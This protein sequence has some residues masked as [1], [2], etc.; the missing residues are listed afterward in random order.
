MIR[1]LSRTLVLVYAKIFYHHKVYGKKNII[2][3]K[4]IVASNHL[5]YL[6]PPLIGIS[7]PGT[8]HFL[9]K[10]ELFKSR[11]LAWFLKKLKAHPIQRG[12]ENVSV[13]R[14]A[15]SLLKKEEKIVLFPE[16]HRSKTGELLKGEAGVGLLVLRTQSPV[17]PVYVHGTY[18]IWDPV[19]KKPKLSGHTACV[20]G[21]PLYF[22]ELF[23]NETKDT[24]QEIA[25]R[26]M[27]RIAELKDWYLK[28]RE[29]SPP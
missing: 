9:A 10:S 17:I 4:A 19:K 12:R 16:G 21:S 6:D 13:F 23:E 26:I 28:G 3:G 15:E 5:S 25:D 22:F 8:I 11:P 27:K 2:Q 24:K 20:F 1:T 29:G 18:E 7:Y 14:L